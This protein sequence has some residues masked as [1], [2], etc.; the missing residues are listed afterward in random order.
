VTLPIWGILLMR[1]VA[2]ITL[3]IFS[4]W[5]FSQPAFADK[6]VALVIG[7]SAY[8][9][10]NRLKNPANDAAAVVAMFKTAGF[11]SVD[12]RQDLNVVEMHALCASLATR[13]AMPMWQ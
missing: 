6:R 3:V 10:V 12:L 4:I 11:D 1:A 7:N 5:I 13:R 8:K 2:T 9:N